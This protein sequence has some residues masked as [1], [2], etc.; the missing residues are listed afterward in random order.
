[1]QESYLTIIAYLQVTGRHSCGR[2][3]IAAVA[4]STLK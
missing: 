4:D 1:L 2:E 3:L